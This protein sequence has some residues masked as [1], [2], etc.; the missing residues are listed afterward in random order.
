MQAIVNQRKKSARALGCYFVWQRVSI[1]NSVAKAPTQQ[2]RDLMYMT[3]FVLFKLSTK[4]NIPEA[5]DQ[6]FCD[7]SHSSRGT[8]ILSL[9]LWI[10]FLVSRAAAKINHTQI[11][12]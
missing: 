6:E 10:R 1:E 3:N 11:G 4:V 5:L 2:V 12:R 8:S 9:K 7:W